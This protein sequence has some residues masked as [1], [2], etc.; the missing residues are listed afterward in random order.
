VN[1]IV[2]YTVALD[3]APVYDAAISWDDVS[4]YWQKLRPLYPDADDATIT[5]ALRGSFDHLR[6]TAET[7]SFAASV[8]CL[9]RTLIAALYL[10][11]TACEPG[12]GCP[13]EL[14]CRDDGPVIE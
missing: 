1:A 11:G 6:G 3:A 12:A 8:R 2:A 13:P 4:A 5:A 14:R 10:T 9:L 7:I